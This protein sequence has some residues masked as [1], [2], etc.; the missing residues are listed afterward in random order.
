MIGVWRPRRD[1]NPCY[2]R[3]S[4]APNRN[5]NERLRIRMH[6][7]ESQQPQRTAFLLR[8][9]PQRLNAIAAVAIRAA[10]SD[11]TD[12]HRAFMTI[13]SYFQS[14]AAQPQSEN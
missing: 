13:P 9:C 12:F 6:R 10:Q 8:R 7:K 1:L 11:T 5:P 3:E 14:L 2:R 4:L